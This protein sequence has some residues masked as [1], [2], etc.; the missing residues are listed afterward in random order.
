MDAIGALGPC[1]IPIA[2]AAA[3]QLRGERLRL[4]RGVPI[5][6]L[7]EPSPSCWSDLESGIPLFFF[8]RK[9]EDNVNSGPTSSFPLFGADSHLARG[10]VYKLP[11]SI[12]DWSVSPQKQAKST[13]DR[14][15]S[16]VCKLVRGRFVNRPLL[17]MMRWGD[18]F[19]SEAGTRNIRPKNGG[20]TLSWQMW[21]CNG[22]RSWYGSIKIGQSLEV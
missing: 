3:W 18:C 1:K 15:P 16:G 8:L 10:A 12:V 19:S 22:H 7:P 17:G 21:T 9:I 13:I 20:G 6:V 11:P 14:E 5:P 4:M 2:Y